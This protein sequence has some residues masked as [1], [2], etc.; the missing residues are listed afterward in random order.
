MNVKLY[1]VRF[2]RAVDV[3]DRAH[4]RLTAS[5]SRAI[6][7]DKHEIAIKVRCE[8]GEEPLHEGMMTWQDEKSR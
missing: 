4:M 7:E 1:P 3:S 6:Q 2:A 8:Y 5:E